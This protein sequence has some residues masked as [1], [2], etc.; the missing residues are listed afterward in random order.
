[1]PVRQRRHTHTH[2]HTQ[3]CKIG[4]RGGLQPRHLLVR[5]SAGATAGVLAAASLKQLLAQSGVRAGLA[6]DD[7]P[8]ENGLKELVCPP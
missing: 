8:V 7:D 6:A 3:T 4:L 5:L 2:T 1:M